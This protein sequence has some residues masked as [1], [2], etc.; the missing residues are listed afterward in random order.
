[1]SKLENC[2]IV[3]YPKDETKLPEVPAEYC[4]IKLFKP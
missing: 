1:M 3:A 2:G 4:G